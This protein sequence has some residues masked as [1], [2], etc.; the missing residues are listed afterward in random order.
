MATA[1]VYRCLYKVQNC[2][3]CN[4]PNRPMAYV[5]SFSGILKVVPSS[6]RMVTPPA[7]ARSPPHSHHTQGSQKN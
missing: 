7:V 1:N 3:P 5:S 4:R 2:T 6:P